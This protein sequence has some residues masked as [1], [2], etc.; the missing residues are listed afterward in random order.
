MTLRE[1]GLNL[2]MAQQDSQRSEIT[3]K[4]KYV[5]QSL[6]LTLQYIVCKTCE[7]VLSMRIGAV[8]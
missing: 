7:N 4:R 8:M 1:G 6:L 3:E 5:I 2:N